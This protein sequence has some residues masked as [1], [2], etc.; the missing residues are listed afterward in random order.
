[1]NRDLTLA[2]LSMD[3]Y[4]DGQSLGL[5]TKIQSQ[6]AD[7][8]FAA[9]AYNYNGETII[10]YRGT[11]GGSDVLNGWVG[12]LGFNATQAGLAVEFYRD[13]VWS[14]SNGGTDFPYSTAG[15][16]TFTGHSLGGGLAGLMGSLYGAKAV[17]FDNMAFRSAATSI[18][19]NAVYDLNLMFDVYGTATPVAPNSSGVFGHRMDG[20]FLNFQ[21]EGEMV[22][23]NVD[24]G[25]GPFD[26]HS[27][28]LLV[29]NMYAEQQGLI[30]SDAKAMT[31]YI[32]TELLAE[33]RV[34]D[35]AY[36]VVDEGTMPKGNVAARDLFDDMADVG[37]LILANKN[38]AV[39]A[40]GEDNKKNLGEI[41]VEFANLH[42]DGKA[43]AASGQTQFGVFHKGEQGLFLSLDDAAWG[44]SVLQGWSDMKSHAIEQITATGNVLP[45]AA[46]T[47]LDNV[48]YAYFHN[49]GTIDIALN[50]DNPLVQTGQLNNA[51]NAGGAVFGSNENDNISGGNGNDF[52]RGGDGRDV[53]SGASGNDAL[54]GGRGNDT[55]VGGDGVD[56]L[57]GGE[58]SDVLILGN[59]D[60][61]NAPGYV[62]GSG[63]IDGDAGSDYLVVTGA[64]GST[65]T[66]GKG[67]ADDRLLVHTS[68]LGLPDAGGGKIGM[69][70][71]LGGVF[72]AAIGLEEFAT[73]EISLNSNLFSNNQGRAYRVFFYSDQ[74]DKSHYPSGGETYAAAGGHPYNF[75]TDILASVNSLYVIE[76]R[77]FVDDGHLE[78]QVLGALPDSYINNDPVLNPD[79]SIRSV[80]QTIVINDFQEGDY[81]IHLGDVF[82]PFGNL[83]IGG[84]LPYNSDYLGAFDPIA[85]AAYNT[86]INLI[87]A[88]A[89]A[90]SLASDGALQGAALRSAFSA[91]SAIPEITADHLVIAI[92][93]SDK[94]DTLQGNGVSERI[95]GGAGNDIISGGAGADQLNGGD[96]VD[97]LDYASSA[98]GV[99]INLALG[100]ASGGDAQGDGFVQ[101]EYVLGSQ[102]VDQLIG[103]DGINRLVGNGGND[104]L[105]G[106]AGN[107]ILIGGAGADTLIGGDGDRDV[108]DYRG[109]SSGVT[110]HL[111][112]G[113]TAGEAAGDTFSGIEYVYGSALNDTI[114]GNTGINRL[115][116][117]AGNDILNGG[118][119]NDILV[120]GTGADTLIGGDGAQDAASYQDAIAGVIVNLVSGG[121]G[122]EAAGDT[123]SGIEYVYGSAFNDS[124][125]G[126]AAINRLTGGAGNDALNG[127]AGNDYLL[128]ELGNDVVTGGAGA[129][130]FVFDKSFGQ[131][132]ITDF[133]A[134]TGRTDRV[135]IT[136]TGIHS[137]ADVLSHSINS[138]GGVVFTVSAEDRITFSGITVAQLVADDFLFV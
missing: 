100:T 80:L 22:G 122:G 95:S 48:N 115:V 77:H 10:S 40:D 108:A 132:T 131:D 88:N 91:S 73:R 31:K 72:E 44:T 67:D 94:A 81:G 93:G 96:G 113:G 21:S 43:M 3:A 54:L 63:V 64:V 111:V 12:G 20:Q 27:I 2:V 24:W 16:V 125:T 8:G 76:Y 89:L 26:L 57:L 84:I 55:L 99:I 112:T 53:L 135:W 137:F 138:F 133:W 126:D 86:A 15:S 107:D 134:G 66:V 32:G 50:G 62:T 129:D 25:L 35:I 109:A 121:T 37:Q 82:L 119:G 1:M 102:Q 58:S 78:I 18:S 59:I 45:A 47:I 118:D 83:A 4:F 46:K 130:V 23:L 98:A 13:V 101:F 97:T 114:T 36:S 38:M 49:G 120:G 128:G 71:L 5:A 68:L 65:V 34:T 14:D 60:G 123:F 75:T 41:I 103:D 29:L 106:G 79:D 39:G 52:I 19:A 90:Y 42:A 70:D 116:G 61:V 11:D 136:N 69:F 30:S 74:I 28:A 56:I 33:G 85:V 110:V 92:D 9:V 7:G 104:V 6:S 17:M 105:N 127:A 51:E 124:L 87:S 117:D